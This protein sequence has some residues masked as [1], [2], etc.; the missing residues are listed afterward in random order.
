LTGA[1]SHSPA[2]DP[3]AAASGRIAAIDILRGLTILWIFAYHVWI[4][5][6]HSF[7]GSEPLYIALRDRVTEGH[8][9]AAAGALLELVVGSGYEGVIVFMMLSGVSLTM[10]A[11]RRGE[12]P[13]LD[14]YQ[15]RFRKLLVPYWAGVTLIIGTIALVAL[16]QM[17]IDGGTFLRQW[18]R[19]TLDHTFPVKLRAEGALQAMTVFGDFVREPRGFEPSSGGLWFIPLLL[20]YYLVFPFAFR[21]LKRMGPWPF[22]V[23]GLV[24]IC[25]ARAVAN[26]IAESNFDFIQL[27][28]WEGHYG[29][30]RGSEFIMGMVLGS[31]FVHHKD[32]VREWTGAALDVAGILVLA[33]LLQLAGSVM[34]GR[35]QLFDVLSFP[36]LHL[37]L[38]LFIVPL[39]FKSPGRLE[40]TWP[41]KALSFLGVVAFTALI[42]NEC[43]R[44][45]SSFLQYEGVP[46]AIWW[47][48]IVAIYIPAGTLLAYP[49]AKLL[50]LLPGQRTP[51]S[52]AVLPSA[53]ASGLASGG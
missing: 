19:V 8:V 3:A 37:G 35:S 49:L 11:Y 43:M 34:T 2:P 46:R 52:T 12:P 14:G 47:S 25:V 26:Q 42:T 17:L 53:A 7:A 29:V 44:F 27:A 6:T 9:Y 40:G 5:Q 31:L 24:L 20:Q 28:R 41:A 38:A 4:D 30:L 51:R 48:F 32:A 23:I 22:L 33:V 36:I 1:D 45:V 10:N 15:S 50:G 39:L 13:A 21:A 18:D 16:F